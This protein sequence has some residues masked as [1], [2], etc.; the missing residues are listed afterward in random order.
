MGAGGLAIAATFVAIWASAFTVAG[1]VV[2]EWPPLWALAIRF[3]CT[4]PILLIV[5]LA[6]RARLPSLPDAGRVALLGLFGMG[7][8]L[9]F[10][11]L[12]MARIPTGLVALICATTPLMIA[13]GESVFMKKPLPP[14]AWVGLAIGWSGVALLGFLRAL[15]GLAAAEATGFVLAIGAATA[16]AAGLLIY[17]PAKARVNLWMASLGQTVVSALF[18]LMLALLLEAEA[19]R[20][21]GWFTLG[22]LLWSMFVVGIGGYALYFVML[23]R[24]PTSTASALQL[25]SPPVAAVFGWA[26]LGERLFVS[27]IVGGL[28]TLGGLWL[29]VR[30]RA[31]ARG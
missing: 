8:Y 23:K 13:A 28:L 25:L 3:G 31:R 15:D 2:R 14:L 6:L 12:A 7:G 18:C 19:P 30:A 21:A 11:W 16:Q 10:A 17:A 29:L 24:V 20:S 4:A 5:A 22:G 26:L 27:D 1:V 9:A